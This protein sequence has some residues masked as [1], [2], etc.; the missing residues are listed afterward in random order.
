MTATYFRIL[1]V[2]SSDKTFMTTLLLLIDARE[3][4]IKSII[5]SEIYHFAA[6]LQN[7]MHYY[8]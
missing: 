3:F 2:Y 6:N 7:I 4:E 8:D 5:E 1:F